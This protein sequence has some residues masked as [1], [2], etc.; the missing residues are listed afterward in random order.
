MAGF[1]ARNHLSA[2]TNNRSDSDSTARANLFYTAPQRIPRPMSLVLSRLELK[3]KT[4]KRYIGYAC[5]LLMAGCASTQTIHNAAGL[6]ENQL[7][8]VKQE[9][10]SWSDNKFKAW[11]SDVYGRDGE[12]IIKNDSFWNP[13]Y[14]SELRIEPGDYIFIVKCE[15][16]FIFTVF[17]RSQQDWR[18]QKNIRCPARKS[19][20][21]MVALLGC[22]KSSE[23][24]RSLSRPTT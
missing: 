21:R 5:L 9:P 14:W 4:V 15:D 1:T 22:P 7:A 18:R 19:S 11:I 17:R 13:R 23:P 2:L 20:M 6:S 24:P 8:L 12:P 16:P 10:V 3:E